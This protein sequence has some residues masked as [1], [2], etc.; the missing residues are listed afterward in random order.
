MVICQHCQ[1]ANRAGMLFCEECGRSLSGL[2]MNATI[3]TRTIQNDPDDSSAKSTWGSASLRK[4]ASIV[5]HFVD[6]EQPMTIEPNRR[7]IFGR[8]DV[9]STINP[10]VDLSPFGGLE[11][12]VS[13]RHAAIE[14]S[15]D[16]LML[17]DMGSS[18]GTFL[19]G[20]RLLPNQPRVLRDGDELRFGKLVAHIYFTFK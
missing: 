4:G 8:S 6:G 18:N 5:L 17:F 11:K 14:P 9:D 13:R 3:P 7:L 1:H 2:P 15:E 19:N 16:T 20:Q 10:D 12:G